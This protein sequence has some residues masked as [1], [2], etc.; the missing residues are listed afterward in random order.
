M[1]L[2]SIAR[3]TGGASRRAAPGSQEGRHLS[4][5]ELGC[6]AESG[7]EGAGPLVGGA[8]VRAGPLEV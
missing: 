8:L 3:L 6:R 4:E 1:P 2:P 7:L 5:T